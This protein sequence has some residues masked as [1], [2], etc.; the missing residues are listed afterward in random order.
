MYWDLLI[1]LFAL[2]NCVMIPLNVAFNIELDEVLPEGLDYCEKVID[3]L[4]VLDIVLNFRT[5]Y[6][7]TKTNLEIVD[8]RRITRNYVNSVRF[9]IDVLA[10][11]PFDYFIIVDKSD[12][13][14]SGN[15]LT[16]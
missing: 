6:I 14:N 7:N 5:T 11:I 8:P 4:F 15:T 16:V 10:S 2:Y 3:V 13:N 1:I 9:P 12:V